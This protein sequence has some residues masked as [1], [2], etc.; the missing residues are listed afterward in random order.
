MGIVRRILGREYIKLFYTTSG[1]LST[2]CCT[3][4]RRFNR[5]VNRQEL[6][7]ICK[8]TGSKLVRYATHKIGS[9]NNQIINVVPQVLRSRQEIDTCIS[10]T[11]PY[12]SLGS[13]GTVVIRQDSMLITLP[14]NVKALSR[15]F[16]IV[17]TRDVNCRRGGIILFS[18]CNF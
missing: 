17:T 12:R 13:H 7:L 10:R 6:T 5:H 4:T 14:K 9:T 15:V 1:G 18:L 16:A 3:V 8:N 2:G 11:I